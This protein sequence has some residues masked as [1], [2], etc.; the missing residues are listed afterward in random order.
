MS[1]DVDLEIL[2][3]GG[4]EIHIE[5]STDDYSRR[6]VDYQIPYRDGA[7]LEDLGRQPRPSSFRA[8]FFGE[9]YLPRLVDFLQEVDKG[10]TQTLRHPLL[11]QWEAKCT[12]AV[13]DHSHERRDFAAVDLEFLEDG[14][15]TTIPDVFSVGAAQKE[16]E[17]DITALSDATDD[18]P[19]E[20]DTLTTLL[21]DANT[22]IEDVDAQI[23]DLTSRFDRIKKSAA[24]AV[25]ELEQKVADTVNWEAVK[26]ARRVVNSAS[27]LKERIERLAPRVTDFEVGSHTPL[28]EIA[29]RRY[30]DPERADELMRVN[31]IRDPFLVPPGTKLKVY[32]G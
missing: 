6:I 13:V 22:F 11:G 5:Q 2:T 29:M 24:E 15:D 18:L 1:W 10:K 26:A 17:E 14:L 4:I 21:N 27:K 32:S 19:V 31:K 28:M 9:D 23:T 8:I 25:E 30:G 7:E 12:R 3:W 16:M 20:I